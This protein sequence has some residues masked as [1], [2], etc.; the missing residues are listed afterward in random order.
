MHSTEPQISLFLEYELR[1]QIV[2]SAIRNKANQVIDD[3]ILLDDIEDA[4]FR[5]LMRYIFDSIRNQKDLVLRLTVKQLDF[6][7]AYVRELTI[8][9]N[10]A[11]EQQ[12]I[13]RFLNYLTQKKQVLSL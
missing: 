4:I 3:E 7:I 5:Y 11:P 13:A 2:Y 12:E 10:D 9:T 8:A 6:L 1:L